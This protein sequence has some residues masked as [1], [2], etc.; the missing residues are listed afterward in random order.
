MANEHIGAQRILDAIGFLPEGKAANKLLLSL[1]GYDVRVTL[2]QLHPEKS[3]V[4]Y[5]PKIKVNH[6]AI[7]GVCRAF[8]G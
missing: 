7:L 2:D 6:K 8:S 3:S 4:D 5:G 1:N